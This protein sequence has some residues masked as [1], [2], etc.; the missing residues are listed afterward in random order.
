MEG[1]YCKWCTLPGPGQWAEVPECSRMNS[2]NSRTTTNTHRI[3]DCD[4]DKDSTGLTVVFTGITGRSTLYSRSGHGPQFD[5]TTAH[6]DTD[7]LTDWRCPVSPASSRRVSLERK[8]ALLRHATRRG[9]TPALLLVVLSCPAST[10]Y[11]ALTLDVANTCSSLA[12]LHQQ[13][14][15]KHWLKERRDFNGGV[16]RSSCFEMKHSIR[17]EEN[18]FEVAEILKSEYNKSPKS[19]QFCLI[20]CDREHFTN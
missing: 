19:T 11:I 13:S 17:I 9:V 10:P 18:L 3:S 14:Q 16:Y 5:A 8:L 15:L 2:R 12:P 4:T 20:S 6:T 1:K 7:G